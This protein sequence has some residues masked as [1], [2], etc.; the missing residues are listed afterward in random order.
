MKPNV[1]DILELN[2]DR[3]TYNGGRGLGRHFNFVVFVAD[4]APGDKI[5]AEIIESKKNYAVAKLVKVLEP[6]PNRIDPLCEYY[7]H[8]GGCQLQHITYNEQ[9]TQKKSFIEKSIKN[10]KVNI[11]TDVI[12]SPK[13]YNYRNRIQLHNKNKKLGYFK[14]KTHDLI[15]INK[16]IIADERINNELKN[17]S[18]NSPRIEV[19]LTKDGSIVTRNPKKLDAH[20]LFSQVNS[21]VND[22][23]INHVI[24]AASESSYAKIYDAYCGQ[25]NFT[26]PLYEKFNSTPITGI[27]YSSN[28]ITAAKKLNN[29][30]NFVENSVE[31]YFKSNPAEKDSLVVL[32]PPRSG[33]HKSVFNGIIESKKIIYISCDLSTFERDA[34]IIMSS[35]YNLD[36]LT[37]FD[38]FPQTSHIEVC[39]VFS[40]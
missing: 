9:L 40:K 15:E 7:N 28:N 2:I 23:L 39:G 32:D 14:K 1:G 38:M 8:C 4:T 10:L 16:C 13:E 11:A 18:S 6:G 19:A 35:G 12:P 25:G 20:S 33:C 36:K 34:K 3:L 30:I 5:S 37:G 27:E 24:M 21:H 26:L 22:L 17:I 29:K 31:K